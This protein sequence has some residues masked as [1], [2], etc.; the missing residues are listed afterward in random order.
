M[1]L[2]KHGA[3]SVVQG[4]DSWKSSG[5]PF[6]SISLRWVDPVCQPEPGEPRIVRGSTPR[7]AR[8]D[9]HQC[10]VV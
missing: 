4:P 2:R 1:W 10:R 6:K 8:H 3:R 7:V 9:S 5:S